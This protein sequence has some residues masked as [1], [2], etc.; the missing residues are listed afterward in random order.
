MGRDFGALKGVGVVDQKPS[1]CHACFFCF[2][3]RIPRLLCFFDWGALFVIFF[4]LR[5][6]TAPY[7]RSAELQTIKKTVRLISL[8]P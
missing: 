4:F 5:G 8:L 3:F 1:E 2:F 6:F 7:Q